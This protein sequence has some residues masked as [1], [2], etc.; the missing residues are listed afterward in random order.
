MVESKKRTGVESARLNGVKRA[1]LEV[2]QTLYIQNLNDKVNRKL[3][4]HTL[5]LLFSTFGEVFEMN[6][7]LRGQAHVVFQDVESATHALKA[8][9]STRVFGKEMKIDFAKTKS[10]IIADAEAALAEQPDHT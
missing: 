6:M 10:R 3:L 2:Q 4:K 8:M 9:G 1:R 5:Y 7:K